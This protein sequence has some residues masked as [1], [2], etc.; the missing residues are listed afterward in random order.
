MYR[1]LEPALAF[2]LEINRMRNFNLDQIYT[3]N[4]RMHVYMAKA[5]VRDCC[6][7]LNLI[8]NFQSTFARSC[9]YAIFSFSLPILD[10]VYNFCLY[11]KFIQA[12]KSRISASLSVSSSVIRTLSQKKPPSNTCRTKQNAVSWKRWTLWSWPGTSI[13]ALARIATTCS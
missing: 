12:R 5:K 10:K 3:L 6:L 4:R 1:G 9:R 2:Q 8:P 13:M 7:T 11:R